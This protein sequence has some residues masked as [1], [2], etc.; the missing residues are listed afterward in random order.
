MEEGAIRR[1]F[2]EMAAVGPEA[3]KS[4]EVAL[5]AFRRFAKKLRLE[6]VTDVGTDIALDESA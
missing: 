6:V 2:L 1:T 3:R 5:A 4:Y